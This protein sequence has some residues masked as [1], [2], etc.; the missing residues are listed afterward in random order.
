MT[1]PDWLGILL[2]IVDPALNTVVMAFH[3]LASLFQ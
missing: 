2:A 1:G 3:A